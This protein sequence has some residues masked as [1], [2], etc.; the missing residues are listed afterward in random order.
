MKP[1]RENLPHGL[2]YGTKRGAAYSCLAITI[3]R[4]EI[5]SSLKG[6]TE[7]EHV[8]SPRDDTGQKAA[9]IRIEWP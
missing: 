4:R 2:W 9:L 6:E 3:Y 1:V 7:K 5:W 8:G